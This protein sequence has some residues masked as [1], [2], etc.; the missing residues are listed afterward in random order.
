MNFPNPEQTLLIRKTKEMLRDNLSDRLQ[1]M[2]MYE[3]QSNMW[4]VSGG[5]IAALLRGEVPNDYDIYFR[6]ESTM[7]YVTSLITDT[8]DLLQ[9]VQDVE[10]KYREYK[11]KDGKCITECAITM[12]NGLQFITKHCG[13]D[14]SVRDTF[15]FVHCMPVYSLHD[16]K[17]RISED[18]FNC[19]VNK[20][21]K[22]NCAPAVTESRIL[23]FEKQGY[24]Q[25]V[26]K[27]VMQIEIEDDF[28]K[29]LFGTK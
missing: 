2:N 23:K 7:N 14:I 25:A 9:H 18:Q 24:K 1:I 20:L 4:F 21:L 27:P 29:Q 26:T 3:L 6:S 8:P 11:G 19:C 17:L 5:C 10:E 15:D 22:V 12:K 13:D 28:V 16:Q